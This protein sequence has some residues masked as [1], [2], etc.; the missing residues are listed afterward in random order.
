MLFIYDVLA[1]KCYKCYI[2]ILI[3]KFLILM[4]VCVKYKGL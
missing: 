4:K 1:I 3:R 2:K